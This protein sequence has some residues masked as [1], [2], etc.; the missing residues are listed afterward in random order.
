MELTS[1]DRVRTAEFA[2]K[3][4][5]YDTD[6]VDAFLDE[7]AEGVDGLLARVRTA[8]STSQERAAGALEAPSEAPALV[9]AA[10]PEPAPAPEARPAGELGVGEGAVGRALVLAQRMADQLLEEA[11]ETARAVR[12]DAWAD[13]EKIRSTA[14]SEAEEL[15]EELERRRR[16]LEQQ[17]ADLTYWVEGRRKGLEE[18]L[19]GALQR[20]D[21]WLDREPAVV[22]TSA[23]PSPAAALSAPPPQL[24]AY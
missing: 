24:G 14:V 11:K 16:D 23:S 15:V 3:M 9:P 17:L 1:S 4:R 22:G 18:A 2:V 12:E 13:A 7:L 19:S 10:P 8:E 21:D 20:L 5:G 6:Q